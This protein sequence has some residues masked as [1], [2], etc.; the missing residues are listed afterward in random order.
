MDEDR[1]LLARGVLGGAI[2]ILLHLKNGWWL[3]AGDRVAQ[4]LITLGV[5]AVIVGMWKH[6]TAPAYL[7]V[8]QLWIGF[9]LTS[10]LILFTIGPGSIFPIVLI[11][12]VL[13][14]LGAVLGGA[15][16]GTLRDRFI[17]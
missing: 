14:S 4:M 5:A 2:A 15:L 7:R 10:S 6:G 3:D 12:I 9:V 1:A 17:R 11:G 8:A 13:L 16:I